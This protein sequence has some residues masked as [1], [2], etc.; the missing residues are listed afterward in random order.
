MAS[1]GPRCMVPGVTTSPC[2]PRSRFPT[3]ALVAL[4]LAN[5]TLL[6][7]AEYQHYEGQHPW[8]PFLWEFSSAAVV[9]HR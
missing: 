3:W 6:G 1:D 4:M 5:G 9:G 7:L 8:E 2:S